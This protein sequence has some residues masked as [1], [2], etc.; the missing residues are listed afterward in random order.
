L[1]RSALSL[2]FEVDL[3]LA[4]CESSDFALDFLPAASEEV[5]DESAVTV[6]VLTP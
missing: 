1:S 3:A 4:S 2:A 6:A 5:E